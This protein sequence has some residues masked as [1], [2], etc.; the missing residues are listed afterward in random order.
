[1]TGFQIYV[2]VL[3]LFVFLLLASIF[4]SVVAIIVKMT[5]KMIRHGLEDDDIIKE[6]QTSVKPNGV[7]TILV[8]VFN[9]IVAGIL[10][11]FF[12]FSLYVGLTK[13]K[14]PNGIPSIKVVKTASMATKNQKNEYL[15]ENDI[16]DQIQA[17]DLIITHH[18]PKEEE[19]KLYDIVVYA[20]DDAYVIHRIV[21]IEEPNEKQPNERYFLLQGDANDR[22]DIFPVKYEQMQGVY[23]GIRIPFV[24]SFVLF[25]QSPAGWLCIM[26]VLGALIATPILEKKIKKEREKRYQIILLAQKNNEVVVNEVVAI[27]N[28]EVGEETDVTN[29]YPERKDFRTFK[30]KL[31]DADDLIKDRYQKLTDFIARI[32]GVRAIESKK[33]ISFKKGSLP[34]ARFNFRGKT[35]C[36]LL[37]LAPAEYENT[38]YIFT[39]VSS[40]K[41]HANYPMRVKLTSN[42]QT[43]WTEEL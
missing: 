30:E 12:V 10:C 8:N 6:K 40:V 19:L 35:L 22:P 7:G 33:Q 1:M 3:C 5:L 20:V 24:G 17:F 11:C 16:N 38:K 4:I 18:L 28:Q 42:R 25:M 36:C 23:R 32:Q 14:A 13:D 2:F 34:I 29:V 39:D 31:E 15:F 26:L 41:E 37:G 9:C 27:V 43:R 21:G